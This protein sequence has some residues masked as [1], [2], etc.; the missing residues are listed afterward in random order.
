MEA[1]GVVAGGHHRAGEVSTLNL[2]D[3]D[4]SDGEIVVHG[5]GNRQDRLP[6]PV[7]VGEAIAAYLRRGRPITMCRAVFVTASAPIRPISAAGVRAAVRYAC[8]RAGIAEFGSHRL[9]HTTAT[10]LLREGSSLTEIAQV[11]R[12]EYINTTAIYAKVDD[13]ALIEVARPW[14][15]RKS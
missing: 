12:H 6:L 14:P 7:D 10:H 4:W 2:D 5:K 9:R 11:L 13:C 3:I 15:G 8:R 1:H